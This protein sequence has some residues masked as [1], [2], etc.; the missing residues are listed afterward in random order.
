MFYNNFEAFINQFTNNCSISFTHIT[1]H[2]SEYQATTPTCFLDI[3]LRNPDPMSTFL[4]YMLM[5][6]SSSVDVSWIYAHEKFRSGEL[7]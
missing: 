6:S 2:R 5:I 4:G 3:S 1:S 7:L